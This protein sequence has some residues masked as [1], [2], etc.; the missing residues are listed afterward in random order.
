MD[1]V[2]VVVETQT[3]KVQLGD[4]AG[5][6]RELGSREG[7]HEPAFVGS[8]WACLLNE[9]LLTVADHHHVRPV[10]FVVE[11]LRGAVT[12]PAWPEGEVLRIWMDGDETLFRSVLGDVQAD[13]FLVH[14]VL[15]CVL[16][17]L[18]P[19][20]N[21]FLRALPLELEQGR[22]ATITRVRGA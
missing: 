11:C 12:P 9:W 13:R 3:L 20:R 4:V 22:R 5:W 14:H 18:G 17:A 21:A 8:A 15:G 10:Q 2:V 6:A 1:V 7:I 19:L 16:A